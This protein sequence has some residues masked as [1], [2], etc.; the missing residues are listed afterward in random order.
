M[1]SQYLICAKGKFIS[2]KEKIH[3]QNLNYS[4][5]MTIRDGV[6]KY[7][8]IYKEPTFPSRTDKN[9]GKWGNW[10]ETNGQRM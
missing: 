4:W 7:D 3:N 1:C 10:W 6:A 9:F 2:L 8:H 5:I